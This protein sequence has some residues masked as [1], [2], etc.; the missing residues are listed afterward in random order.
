MVRPISFSYP[1]VVD[2]SSDFKSSLLGHGTGASDERF[3][4]A[5]AFFGSWWS[6]PF[7]ALYLSHRVCIE[8]FF[9]AI[10]WFSAFVVMFFTFSNASNFLL[11]YSVMEGS[12]NAACALVWPHVIDL[13]CAGLVVLVVALSNLSGFH[14]PVGAKS[15]RHLF[16]AS[17]C[18]SSMKPSRQV[19]VGHMSRWYQVLV[20]L[21]LLHRGEATNPGPNNLNQPRDRAWS[22][23]TFNPSG[24]GGKEQVVSTFLNH[25]DLW[26]VTETHLTSQGMRSFRQGLKWSDS[27]F[28]YCIGGQPVP[29]R[30]HSHATGSW[31]GV[32]VLSKF[33]T[34]AVPVPWGDQVFQTSRVQ[35][36]ATLCEDMWVTG[37]VLYGEPPGSQH[38]SAKQ[39]TDTLALELVSHLCQL[40][41]L[42]YLGGDFNFEVGGLEVFKVLADA[43]F[44]DIQDIAFE[45]WGKPICKTCK[46]STRKD[47]FFISRELIPFL[48]Q[49]V[50]D[51]TI[52]ADHAVLQGVFRCAP[53]QLTR[54]FWRQPKLVV[55][56]DSFQ[57]NWSSQF[58]QENDP[59]CRYTQM[60]EEV[61]QA[62]SRAAVV[63]GKPVFTSKQCG[64]GSTLDTKVLKS[65]FHLN[66]VK[67]G[68][69]SDVQ[70]VFAGLCQ[71]HA[72]WFRQLRRIQSFVRF[73][74]IHDIDTAN[75]HGVSLWSSIVR[76]KGFEGSFPKWW[77]TQAS[78]VFGAPHLLPMIPPTWERA[79]KIYESFLIDVRSLENSLK[80]K[81][82]QH[83]KD[84]RK[85]LAH[86]I[87]KDIRRSA[88]DRVDVLLKTI[89]GEIVEVNHENNSVMVEDRCSFVQD[90][91]I[92]IE[93]KSLRPLQ[94]DGKR[95]WFVSI[96][97]IEV[98]QQIRQSVFTGQAEELFATFGA[99]WS[100]RWERHQH[101]PASQ[102]EQI[103]EFG[104]RHLHYQPFDLPV[105][106][107]SMIQQE[108]ARKK[109]HSAT[110]LDGV[111]LLDLKSMP[112]PVLAE[113]C[114]LF[115]AAEDNGVWPSQALVGRVASL[116][117]SPEPD[118]VAGFRPITVLPHCYR[119]WSGVRAK[120]LLSAMSSRC[121]SFL[122][123]NKPHCQASMV[124]THLAWAV[125][126]SFASDIP[127]AGIVADIEKA[128]NHLPREVVFQAA[129]AL[130]LPFQVLKAWSAAM[131]GLERRFQIR[132]HLGPAVR[133][134]TG[135]PEG[136]A[137]SCLA[138]M[139]L[140]CL[141]HRWFEVQFP[142]CQPVSYVDD[143]QLLTREVQ[144]IPDMLCE[145]HSFSSL[146]D[147]TVDQK[148]TFV[149]CTSSYHRSQFRKQAL[150]VKKHARG[151]GA[152][153]Q[154]GRQ[155]STEIIR[156]RIAE[157]TPLWPRLASSLS[158][159][160]VKVLAIKQAAWS[161]C[162]HAIAAT[163]ISQDTFVSLRT[164]AMRGLNAEGAGCNPCIHLGMI[165]NPFLDPFFWSVVA[166]IRTT[167]ECTTREGLTPLLQDVVSGH[168]KLP[169]HGMTSILVSRLH[170]VGWEITSGVNCRDGLGEISLFDTSFP[171]IVL[172]LSW[173]WQKCVAAVV[174][175]RSTF[176]GLAECD[177]ALT[178]EFLSVLP[179]CEQGLMRKSL[180]GA[181]FTNDSVCHFST[182]GSTCCQ[183]CG[184]IDSRWHR[185]WECEVFAESRVVDI[186]GFWTDI[187]IFPKSLMCHG[188]ALRPSTWTFW[189]QALLQIQLPHVS[190]TSKPLGDTWVD[191]FTDGSCLWPKDK[192]MRLASWSV[193]EASPSGQT[194]ESQ[195]VWAG[196]VSGLLQSAY[197]AELQAV[198]CAVR[199]ALFWK[200][201]VRIWSDCQSVVQRFSQ[202]VHHNRQLKPNGPHTDLWSEI[203]DVVHRLG[204]DSVLI[205]KVAAHQDVSAV[206]SAFENW[207]FQHNIVADRAAR[208]ANLQRES[209]FWDLHKQHSLEATWAREVSHAVFKVI[210][211]ISRAVVSR[212]EVLVVDETVSPQPLE[213][214]DP[215]MVAVAPLW[216]GFVP[217]TPLP[218]ETTRRYGHR[219]VATLVAWIKEALRNFTP[220]CQTSW[221]SVFQLYLDF[222]H[223]T[224]ELGLVHDKSWKDPEIFPG[225]KLVPKTFK[226][227]S[228]W[229]GKVL[230]SVLRSYGVETPWMVTRPKSHMI[231]LHTACLAFPW[232][233]WRL[234]VIEN[235]ISTH[236]PAKKAA[237]RG[238]LDLVHLP[239]AKQSEQW[240]FL[241]RCVGPLGS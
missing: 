163:S 16:C 241:D 226:R 136:C 33:P 169:A 161:R 166:T 74:K 43:G 92:F 176:D 46:Q 38:P 114:K 69:T 113:H 112:T 73:R 79:V 85:E 24:L 125:E 233:E 101:V 77:E 83:A 223:Q 236:L 11:Y 158:P 90:R 100:K 154:F 71:Q 64:R 218:L 124:W 142:L 31:N 7:T 199:Y 39:N 214:V 63:Q 194:H 227:R 217:S 149:W 19:G 120:A 173:S 57:V 204:A 27:E 170:H 234:K 15:H 131:G 72:H 5:F 1:K 156:T 171:E 182:S 126:E 174:A 8:S 151:L 187:S 104:R 30:S 91:D 111:S 147:L 49:V 80:S 201:K 215:V 172:R 213:R 86:L 26:A 202:L 135:Y 93:G 87:F 145:L 9:H 4:G 189:Q 47:F 140:D 94:V 123:G 55:W 197:R 108:L 211:Q 220:G 203:L 146:V 48:E 188:W 21:M 216:D 99:E 175:H 165:E 164:L 20:I 22:M 180:N 130:G 191:L 167:R 195:V 231:A 102:W 219:F 105:W 60:W 50:V 2:H 45:K 116:A 6:F 137:M 134:C 3:F 84:K 198:C 29:L 192:L 106:N 209:A 117:K 150:P 206:P 23:G 148:K 221:I 56:P 78:R 139:L 40:S 121:P 42:R 222:Q 52:W 152:Q 228:T 230:R 208:L 68:R 157:C 59:T 95:I 70:P 200:R 32:A 66:P 10:S 107:P 132:E 82:M 14:Q 88:P 225:L 193:V 103:C 239:V 109:P 12:N 190:S 235:W 168:S 186:P 118:S 178:R 153:L 155:H 89:H 144:Q 184:A 18:K 96:Q 129:V 238:G 210:L 44:R 61:E 237:T 65:P 196:Q 62:A 37:G 128:F 240:P 229:F 162:L 183:F 141:F 98:G 177:P 212:E 54:H 41:G 127:L 133:S 179:V 119:L 51:E 224:G 160:K 13:W 75:G 181:L 58:L 67:V 17:T 207:A 159:Y 34:R 76:A 28:V 36:T 81:R 115:Q 35:L 143:L 53:Q 25:G 232:P 97:G 205:T 122:F 110:G 185:F 138:M